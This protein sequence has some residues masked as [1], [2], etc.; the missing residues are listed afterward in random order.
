MSNANRQRLNE[1]PSDVSRR[2]DDTIQDIAEG[3]IEG[4]DLPNLGGSAYSNA[5]GDRIVYD[6][7]KGNLIVLGFSTV[8][9]L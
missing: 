2:I 5:Y 1:L 8:E 3:I 9:D 4:I 7:A 6:L